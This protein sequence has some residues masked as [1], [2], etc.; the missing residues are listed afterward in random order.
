[1]GKNDFFQDFENSKKFWKVLFGGCYNL[2]YFVI[3]MGY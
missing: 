2:K 3:V 1:M